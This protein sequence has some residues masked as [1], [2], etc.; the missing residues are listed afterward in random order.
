MGVSLARALRVAPSV[1]V[2]GEL[3]VGR[4]LSRPLLFHGSSS[5]TFLVPCPRNSVHT[6]LLFFAIIHCHGQ[7]EDEGKWTSCGASG[8]ARQPPR[9]GARPGCG[10]ATPPTWWDRR[11]QAWVRGGGLGWEGSTV[12]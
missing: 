11:A 8:S 12:L 2:V 10:Q 3:A 5:V 1:Q 9:M 6:V 4:A 7:L